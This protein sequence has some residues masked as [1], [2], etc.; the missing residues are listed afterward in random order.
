MPKDSNA[1]EPMQRTVCSIG[2]RRLLLMDIAEVYGANL[3]HSYRTPSYT[4]IYTI[5]RT[6]VRIAV[7]GRTIDVGGG[8]RK[9][10]NKLRE[11]IDM[12]MHE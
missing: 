10:P 5:D 3:R 9:R 6:Y 8:E 1:E 7:G 12:N 11:K 2:F 4:G